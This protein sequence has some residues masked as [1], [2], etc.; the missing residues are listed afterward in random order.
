MATTATIDDIMGFNPSD[1]SAF[2]EKGPKAD[3]NIYKTNP[4]DSKSDDG[5]YR[6]KLKVLLN[7]LD[8]H[9]SIV[10]QATYWLN[11]MDG[12]RPVRSSLSE[13]DKSCALFRAWKRLWFSGDEAKKEF[14]RKVYDKNESYWVIV[15]ILEDENKPE[16]V[17]QFRLMKLAK[18]IYEKLQARM[19]P[20][21]ASGKLP[22]PVMD[23]VI[24]LSLDLEVQPG[25]DDPTQPQRKQR[26]ISYSLSSFGDYATV[27]KTDGTPLLTEDE[28]EL[29]DTYVTAINDSQN[30]KTAKK[31]QEGLT[32]LNEVKPQIRPIYE[33]VISYVEENL[34]DAVTGEKLDI[35]KY[36][37]YT[38]WDDETKEVVRKFTEMTDACVDPSTMTYE[39][40]KAKQAAEVPGADATTAEA[41]AEVK[42]ET[43]S[44]VPEDINN[45]PF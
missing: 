16:L 13:G 8:P 43:P 20:T 30:G 6:A 10:S 23:Y 29:V 15:Q 9:R 19:C 1:L 32:K 41:K 2:Q 42:T 36:C 38:P 5:I 11:M 34:V 25:P 26:E 35:Q 44:V 27:I 45:L 28:V 33:K 40:F 14:S 17:G 18:D 31:K 37:G 39:Q 22:Y 4:K 7:P 24:G 3:P 12:S 21:A